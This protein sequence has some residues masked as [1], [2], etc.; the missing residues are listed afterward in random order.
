MRNNPA[1][2]LIWQGFQNLRNPTQWEIS[3]SFP[4]PSA[5]KTAHRTIIIEAPANE[6]AMQAINTEPITINQC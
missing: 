4:A 3:P 5:T 2:T 6:P 1:Q